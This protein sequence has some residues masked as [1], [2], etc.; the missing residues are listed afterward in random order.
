MIFGDTPLDEAA[1]AILAHSRRLSGRALKKGH[2]L[3][4]EDI[5]ALREAGVE[6]VIA[7]RLEADDVPE[8]RAAA[9]L[10]AAFG[11]ENID[12]AAP[13]TGRCNLIA[14][15]PGVLVYDPAALDA[16]N[17]VDEALTVA[18][19]PPYEVVEAGQMVGT[20]KII[21]FAAPEALLARC[22]ALAPVTRIA[23]FRPLRA[24]LVQTALPATKPSVL[25]STAATTAARLEKIGASLGNEQRCDHETAA[26]AAAIH[27]QIAAGHDLVLLFGASAVVDRRDVLPAGIVAAGGTVDHF[28]MPVDPGNLLLLGHVGDT[29]VIGMPGCARSPKLNGFDW[30]LQRLVAGLPVS[31]VDIMRMGV[32]GLL[33][34]IASRPRPREA[35]DRESAARKAPRIAAL[36]LAG[37]QS[38]RMG[39][40]NKLLA[41]INGKP[42]VAQVVE[43]VRASKAGAITV[44]TGHEG[45]RVKAAL[46]G[47]LAFVDNPDYAGGLS[48]SLK[49]GIAALP[50][51]IDGVLVC[52]G[53]MPR[54][55]PAMIDRLIAAFDPVEGRA[56]CVPTHKGKRGNPVLWGKRFLPEMAALAG[57][58]GAKHLIGEHADLIVEV[59]MAEDG[60]L[61]DIDTPDA[62]TRYRAG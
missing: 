53:D 11:G 39:E 29:P 50:A 47:D 12:I 19:L 41:E 31:R 54:I 30:V 55:L 21:P 40:I 28:G 32:G 22:E 26:V 43:S 62:L 52:L 6:T 36:I 17:L 14:R 1:G 25:D 33:K 37:G 59:E 60:V 48:T 46:P 44:V 45:E 16:V 23:A 51:D 56:I 18:L 27:Q 35:N 49:A 9:R 5:A 2:V 58:V 34:E 42:M 24:G 10:A 13:F 20:V 15:A 8:D 3:T 38:R 4:A 7:A 57:D 61:I